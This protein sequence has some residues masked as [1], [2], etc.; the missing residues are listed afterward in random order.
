MKFRRVIQITAVASLVLCA[1]CYRIET[2]RTGAMGHSSRANTDRKFDET[3]RD[4]GT[5]Y[6]SNHTSRVW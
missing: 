1:G 3:L 2:S 6:E 5:R 4:R